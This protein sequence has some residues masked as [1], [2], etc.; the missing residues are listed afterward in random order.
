MS[1]QRILAQ[2]NNAVP[3]ATVS[4]SSVLPAARQVFQQQTTRAGNGTVALS[5]SYSGAADA[6]IDIEIRTPST[7]AETAT[8]P[9]FSGAGNGTLTG[10][11]IDGGT[12]S[13]DIT[14]TLVDL[15][16]ETTR[17][18]AILYADVLLQAKTAG[19]GGNAISLNLTPTLTLSAAPVGA[20][21][22][23][24]DRGT[25]EWT[26]QRLDFG[27]KALNPDG[28]VP[29]DAPRLV[30]GRD[31][32]RVYRHYK[33]WDGEQWQ[34][35]LSPKLAA[36]YP[37]G[38]EVHTVTGSYSAIVTDGVTPETY[39]SLITL[40]DLLIALGAS[41]LISVATPPANNKKPGGMAAIDMPFR[42][43][44]F[45]LPVEKSRADLPDLAGITV[46][47]TAPTES[48]TLECIDDRFVNQETWS[49]KSKVA[50]A[51]AAASTGTPYTG[52]G[53]VGFTVPTVSLES[54]PVDGRIGI[55]AESY[56]REAGDET[57]T[58]A[59]CLYR[60]IIGA[61]AKEKSLKLIWTQ[62]PADD[63]SCTDSSVTGRPLE[64]FLG[65]DLGDEDMA[66]LLAGHRARLEALTNWYKTFVAANTEKTAA[67]EVRSAENDIRLAELAA[68]ELNDCLTDLYTN[69]DAVL[70]EDSWAGSTAY[71]VDAVVEPA[72]PNGYRYRA[73]VGGTSSSSAPTWPTTIG[74]TVTDGGVTW[75]CVTK[76]APLA[77]DAV[78][79]GLSSDLIG[80][81]GIDN[82]KLAITIPDETAKLSSSSSDYGVSSLP[83]EGTTEIN[84]IARDGVAH[85]YFC[86]QVELWSGFTAARYEIPDH[87]DG[88]IKK[89]RLS[90]STSP[91][92]LLSGMAAWQDLGVA[93]SGNADI[94]GIVGR[95]SQAGILFEPDEFVK[96]YATACD[97]LR[98]IAGLPP[99][100][101]NAGLQ[102]SAIWRDLG[103]DY[104]VVS[105]ED[106]LPIFSNV[107]YHACVEKTDVDGNTF[108]EPTYEFGFAVRVGCID[109]LEYG[110]SITI[111]IGDVS[112][113]RPY[114]KG[115]TYAIPVVQGGPLAFAGG[116]TG[117]DT[118]TWTVNSSTAGALD[119]YAIDLDEDPYADGGLNF[120]IHRG[121]IPFALGDA[122]S[123]SVEVGGRFRWRKDAGSWSSDTAIADTVS[124]ADGLSALFQ[125]GAA[126]AFVYGDTYSY[127]LRQPNAP[128][129]TQS[130]HGET[131]QWSST[132]ATLTLTWAS[133]QTVSVVGLL[134][135]G[136]ASPATVSIVLKNSG[137]TTLATITPT[138][139]NGPLLTALASPLTTVRS[140]VVTV[141]SASGMSLGW[142]YAG[143]PFAAPYDAKMTWR[144]AYAMDRSNGINPRAAYLGAGRAGEMAWQDFLS[145]EAAD[146]LLA[147]IDDCKSDGDA[148]IIIVPQILFPQDA[149]LARIDTDAVDL[150][151][152]YEFQPDD[153]ARRALSLMLPLAPVLS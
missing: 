68:G 70:V 106:Y 82:E 23:K 146:T 50:G 60:P 85:R 29:A 92:P 122:F 47:S 66:A 112:V 30:F 148:P 52:G 14:V 142:V 48:V 149:I 25:Q 91:N 74:N 115:D 69:A 24:L 144:R 67:G 54:R 16:T 138:V 100:K 64:K 95:S 129:H 139:A 32:S 41:S 27:S 104:W 15:G 3:T 109:R 132:G 35:G 44:A 78:L 11:S 110:D 96:R 111:T 120:T 72:A 116:V 57:G 34:Y 125:S 141:A 108:I 150:T 77:W 36:S 98:A 75:K 117:D 152:W 5:G 45:A 28:T 136:L 56:P 140:M 55:S 97:E 9:V 37:Q 101:S 80:L 93:S 1:V 86:V 119:D 88:S 118:L 7:G 21:A 40:Y 49:V 126:P 61:A 143:V 26:D 134:R 2:I 99:K 13:Q 113:N 19:A 121:A 6:T 145:Q 151:D 79:A 33:R 89:Y 153:R 76:T 17:A 38:A 103:T 39:S 124:L 81:A 131:W 71:A 31:L 18:Q 123:F 4:A 135:H 83:S 114:V 53:F 130:A 84:A 46:A 94:N 42:T 127:T 8:T 137:G 73:T 63:C 65:V 58:P 128:D 10:L 43:A 90:D 62:R 12:V 87:T 51:L 102:G 147:M 22:D 20:L 59:I 105:G 107:Y 133:D